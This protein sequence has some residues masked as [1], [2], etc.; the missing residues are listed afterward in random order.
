MK[1]VL[2]AAGG[3]MGHLGPAIA[4][5]DVLRE[6]AP[7]SKI[8]F[9]GTRSGVERRVELDFPTRSIIKV[10][11]P[12][13]F[14]IALLL[15]PFRFLIALLQSLPLV[16]RSEVVVGFGGYVAT[17]IYLAAW[18]LRKRIILHE[19]NALPGF[20][21]RVGR[22]LGAD[23][24]ANFERVAIAW[25]CPAIGIPLRSEIIE[26]ARSGTSTPS[27]ISARE[28]LVVGGSQGSN[29]LNQAIWGAIPHLL[30]MDVNVKFHHSVG[31]EHLSKV[32]AGLAGDA[33]RPVGY[34]DDMAEAYRRADLVIARGGAVTC[35][36]ILALG[37]RA[38][39]VPLGH[40]N[41]E[42]SINGQALVENGNAI[43][44]S[45]SQFD[46]EW[47]V[48]N[49]TRALS[50]TPSNPDRN[51]LESHYLNATTV[52]VDAIL[53]VASKARS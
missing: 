38:I 41:G 18:I 24:F 21:N 26:L 10:P 48:K 20:A 9:V 50:L 28:V 17:P 23:C 15:F 37:K 46:A 36:E 1:S 53:A 32:P 51:S 35:A 11:L 30:E 19:A 40:G 16:L 39:V 34:I 44:V 12:R 43:S 31:P 45:D 33:Y 27:Q 7:H 3:T 14:G 2:F 47:L 42:Q 22:A 25:H 29:S 52:M 6:R 49:L 5:A 4:V 13:R 8:L